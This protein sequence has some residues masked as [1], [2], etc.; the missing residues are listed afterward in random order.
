M[1]FPRI[2]EAVFF[3]PWSITEAGHAA[4]VD[5][6][7][8]ATAQKVLEREHQHELAKLSLQV[9]LAPELAKR[10]TEDF[11]HNPIEQ[12]EIKNGIA[13][14]PIK[15][16]MGK[17]LSMME[18]KCG[19]LSYSDIAEDL[20][21]ANANP[22]V[23]GIVLDINSPGGMTNGA[24]DVAQI[25]ADIQRAE[26][27][28]IFAFTDMQMCSAAYW[29]ASGAT[30]IYATP[31]SWVGSIGAMIPVLDYS[32]A[33]KQKGIA[34]DI[35]R[36]GKH[37]GAGFPGTKLSDEQRQH[38]QDIVDASYKAFTDHVSQFRGHI[39]SETMQGQ[40]F[41]GSRAKDLELVDGL[42]NSIEEVFAKI[43]A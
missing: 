20:L 17:H 5:V 42:V 31:F 24:G 26:K 14:I 32:E 18:K 13:R 41:N 29:I 28:P 43:A 33:Y 25:V 6:L 34:V 23:R 40:V 16:A 11:F 39:T 35:I 19:G 15:G 30:G 3:H 38:L 10:P 37:K 7:V 9:G 36:G 12:M 27:K 22:N 4:I 8:S 21:A 2:Y 1:N